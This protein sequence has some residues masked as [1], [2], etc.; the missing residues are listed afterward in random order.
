VLPELRHLRRDHGAA[1]ALRGVAPE[2]AL[3]IAF[4]REELAVRH[5][6]RD[7]GVVPDGGGVPLRA[8]GRLA[9]GFGVDEDDAAVLRAL[10]VPL[11]VLRRGIVDGEEDLEQLGVRDHA[12]IEGDLHDLRVAG[13]LVADLLVRRAGHEAA[14]VAADDL[15]DAAKLLEKYSRRTSLKLLGGGGSEQ[16]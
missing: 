2:V 11:A 8:L 10:V 7:D 9:L 12:R 4:G 16:R 15:L 1:V 13:R 6:L 3:V 14:R 5:D